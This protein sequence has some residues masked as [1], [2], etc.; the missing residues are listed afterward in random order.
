MEYAKP[1]AGGWSARRTLFGGDQMKNA[2]DPLL[3][4]SVD[5]A[6][7]RAFFVDPHWARRGLATALYHACARAAHASGFRRFELMATAPGEPF[8][9]QLGFVVLERVELVLPPGVSVPFAR[10]GRSISDPA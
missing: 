9:E 3:D 6:R 1:A 2:D 5:A 8:Y 7:I 4:P 10:M